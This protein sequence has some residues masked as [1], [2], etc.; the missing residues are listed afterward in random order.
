MK[1]ALSFKTPFK[2][3]RSEGLTDDGRF[4]WEVEDDGDM[5]KDD[6][7][8]LVRKNLET[9]TDEFP[10]SNTKVSDPGVKILITQ[11]SEAI[12]AI[13]HLLRDQAVQMDK[14]A[15]DLS[16]KMSS[17]DAA[18]V[19]IKQLQGVVGNPNTTLISG[20]IEPVVWEAIASL[21]G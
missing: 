16:V 10:L 6:F 11:L 5:I 13:D 14:A 20:G 19:Q 15:W 17:A 1:R 9:K 2:T 12:L 8:S 21:F 18:L 4:P 3:K 7:T